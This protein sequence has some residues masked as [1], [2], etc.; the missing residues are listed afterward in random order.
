MLKL[1]TTILFLTFAVYSCSSLSDDGSTTLIKE[2]ANKKQ[3]KKAILFLRE[4]GAT[5]SDS[6]Q[7]IITGN[8]HKL[9]KSEVGNTFTVDT[10]HGKTWLEPTSINLT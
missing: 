5:V 10:D 8:K 2:I 7:V 9:T 4:S 6:Y 3:D 1:K